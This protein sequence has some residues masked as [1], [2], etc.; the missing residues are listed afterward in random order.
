VFIAP[1]STTATEGSERHS[2]NS[3]SMTKSIIK[4]SEDDIT[5]KKTEKSVSLSFSIAGLNIKGDAAGEEMKECFAPSRP[6]V[7]KASPANSFSLKKRSFREEQ[8]SNLE[9]TED[10]TGGPKEI[11]DASVKE[12]IKLID[13]FLAASTTANRVEGSMRRPPLPK[14]AIKKPSVRSIT[15]KDEPTKRSISIEK[16]KS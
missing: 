2:L 9:E 10:E 1:P 5:M 7:L 8:E 11:T 13:V 16:K 12:A 3:F 6:L 4:N 14:T 15:E